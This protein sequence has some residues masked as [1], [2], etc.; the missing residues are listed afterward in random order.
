MDNHDVYITYYIFSLLSLSLSLCSF[1]LL[2]FFSLSFCLPLFSF[3]FS[4]Y[5]SLFTISLSSSFYFWF[6]PL[7]FF[8]YIFTSVR[9]LVC[10]FVIDCTGCGNSFDD[11]RERHGVEF[12]SSSL[13]LSLLPSCLR[14]PILPLFTSLLHHISL[15]FNFSTSLSLSLSNWKI[16]TGISIVIRARLQRS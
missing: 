2:N 5:P 7:F 4:L 1:V 16:C 6:C 11:W 15:F 14:R 13:C 12:Y 10:F 9:G 3:S 8:P